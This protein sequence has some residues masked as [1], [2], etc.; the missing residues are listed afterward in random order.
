MSSALAP[1][2]RRLDALEPMQ[3]VGAVK[4]AVGLVIESQGPAV[5]VGDVCYLEPRDGGMETPLEVIGYRRIVDG[6]LR[7]TNR[8]LRR[9][10]RRKIDAARHDGEADDSRC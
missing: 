6:R 9:L 8:H 5:S 1:Y 10:G 2:F 4:R 3:S 7:S